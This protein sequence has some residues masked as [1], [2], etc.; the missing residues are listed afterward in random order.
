MHR[1]ITHKN[2]NYNCRVIIY[3]SR[4]LLIRPKQYLA[5]DGNYRELRHFAPWSKPRTVEQHSLPTVIRD[6]MGQKNVE[7]G[8]GVVETEDTVFGVEMCEELFTPAS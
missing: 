3:N 1:P 7:F 8:D 2:N 4:I 5:N 6:V